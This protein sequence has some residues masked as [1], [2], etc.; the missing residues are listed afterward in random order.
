MIIVELICS[1]LFS[2]LLM[3]GIKFQ[4]SSAK[5]H[6]L[7]ISIGMVIWVS[8]TYCTWL[9]FFVVLPENTPDSFPEMSFSQ[10]FSVLTD[11]LTEKL[12]SRNDWRFCCLVGVSGLFWRLWLSVSS[13]EAEHE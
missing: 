11:I 7:R 1:A 5:H 13:A 10:R 3:A 4:G 6:R 8:L 9:S 12:Y 2:L